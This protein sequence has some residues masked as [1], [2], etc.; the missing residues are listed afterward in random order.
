MSLFDISYSLAKAT[1]YSLLISLSFSILIAVFKDKKFSLIT[2]YLL[3]AFLFENLG[4]YI[5]QKYG[6]NLFMMPLFYFF[7]YFFWSRFF[8]QFT[9]GIKKY[10]KWVDS[11]VIIYLV[12]EMF[13]F[14]N[15]KGYLIIPGGSVFC[16]CTLLVLMSSYLL[17]L[18]LET[19]SDWAFF[20]ILFLLT[21]ICVFFHLVM[22]FTVYWTDD[23]KYYLWM[24]KNIFVHI[25]YLFLPF[26]QWKNAR[27]PI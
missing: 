11:F 15:G 14:Y 20:S 21:T 2:L 16:L 13:S 26:Y 1:T 24:F 22:R 6:Y 27:T 7:D 12:I 5:A 8:A 19:P 4:G 17:D 18:K 3:I 25:F 10:F 9:T 23:Y